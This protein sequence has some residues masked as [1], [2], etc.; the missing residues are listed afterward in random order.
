MVGIWI[1]FETI[2]KLLH[3]PKTTAIPA[4]V[5]LQ[6]APILPM[7]LS[8]PEEENPMSKT[9]SNAENFPASTETMTT[10]T[11]APTT[12]SAITP[13]SAAAQ[14]LASAKQS[15][16]QILTD[17]LLAVEKLIVIASGDAKALLTEAEAAAI[18]I[19][20]HN[21]PSPF[22]GIVAP[23]AQVAASKIEGAI[24]TAV[25]PAVTTGLG[26]AHNW[27]ESVVTSATYAIERLGTKV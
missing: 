13:A 2:R 6:A 25:E 20:L 27:L 7:P 24:N 3:G 11:D 15:G 18:P 26:I 10:T 12:P 14:V 19:V 9:S 5:A 17:A 1:W 4:L 21:I 23:F 16:I 8:S 22:A